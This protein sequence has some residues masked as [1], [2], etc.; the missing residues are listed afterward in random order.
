MWGGEDWT[1]LRSID[2]A[3][4]NS[5]VTRIDEP[6]SESHALMRLRRMEPHCESRKDSAKTTLE[7]VDATVVEST[8][9][10]GNRDVKV[11]AMS[12]TRPGLLPTVRMPTPT[13]ERS[14]SVPRAQNVGDGGSRLSSPRLTSQ[15]QIPKRQESR[16]SKCG[17]MI[18]KD[19]SKAV[20]KWVTGICRAM[21]I[22]ICGWRATM[23]KLR[24]ALIAPKPNTSGIK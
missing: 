22:R 10:I 24:T 18:G 2:T 16:L 14:K 17:E 19:D 1:Y 7:R 21:L 4:L 23:L 5:A 12:S 3:C 6:R 20:E 15:P 9:S 11:D 13:F 8:Y